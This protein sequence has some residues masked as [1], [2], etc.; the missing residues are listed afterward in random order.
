MWKIIQKNGVGGFFVCLLVSSRTSFSFFKLT[1]LRFLWRCFVT[2]ILKYNLCNVLFL[3]YFVVAE[4]RYSDIVKIQIR[5]K[6]SNWMA[7]FYIGFIFLFMDRGHITF[8]LY[9]WIASYWQKIQTPCL[10]LKGVKP[11]SNWSWNQRNGERMKLIQYFLHLHK[12]EVK[13]GQHRVQK[14]HEVKSFDGN[15]A[16]NVSNF[17][18]LWFFKTFYII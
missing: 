14:V 8:F 1:F 4:F 10:R 12:Q 16:Q 6:N 9:Q 18:T 17:L 11:V 2:I 7:T 3:H 13:L 5:K 15:T